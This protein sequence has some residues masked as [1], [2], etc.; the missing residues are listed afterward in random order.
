MGNRKSNIRKKVTDPEYIK[1]NQEELDAIKERDA[2]TL[3]EMRN[4]K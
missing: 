2:K 3:E 1:K 4:R